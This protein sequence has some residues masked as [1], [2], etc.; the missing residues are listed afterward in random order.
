LNHDIDASRSLLLAAR[1]AAGAQQYPKGALYVV[2]TPIGNLADLTLRA[3]HV[4]ELVDAVACEDTRVAAVL[5]Q[6]LGLHKP[7]IALHEHNEREAAHGVAE[8][9]QRGE[10]IAFVSDAGTPAVSDPGAR[11]V[12]VLREAG[13][14]S[15]PIP[16]PSAV[17]TALSVAGADADDGGFVFAGFLPPKGAARLERLEALAKDNGTLVLYESPHRIATLA[18][19]LGAVMPT[20]DVTVAR[21]LSKQFEEIATMAAQAL[22]AWFESDTNRRRGEFVIVVHATGKA[23]PADAELLLTQHDHLLTA[24]LKVLPLKQAVATAVEIS[25]SARNPLYQRALAL[26]GQGSEDD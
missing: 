21:E 26:K 1:H 22:K 13:L 24:L 7:L 18:A 20:R 6:H 16:G 19:E 4:L 5:M 2:A 11:L 8:R 9:L 14:R 10:R 12:A 17:A 25:G 15:V 3:I 23:A